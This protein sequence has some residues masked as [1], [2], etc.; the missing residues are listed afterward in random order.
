M[1]LPVRLSLGIG[2]ISTEISEARFVKDLAWHDLIGVATWC[3]FADFIDEG[4]VPFNRCLA[5]VETPKTD[6]HGATR[7]IVAGWLAAM[8]RV[9]GLAAFISDKD[10]LSPKMVVS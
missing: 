4:G 10:I 9:N 6:R 1:I 8:E 5:Y 3:V 2:V 7:D